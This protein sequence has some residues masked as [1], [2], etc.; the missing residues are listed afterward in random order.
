M[1]IDFHAHHI[2]L[3]YATR[4]ADLTWRENIQHHIIDVRSKTVVDIGCG[5]G[6]YTLAL[7][8]M[9]ATHVTGIDF[10][11]AEIESAQ[12]RYSAISNI[13]FMVGDAFST[14]L[15]ST[16]YDIV[17][18][19]ALIHHLQQEDLV[20][21]FAEARRILKPRG[22]LIVQDRTPED[23]MLPG[24]ETHIRSYIVTHFPKLLE[25]DV[26]RR[27]SS[28]IVIDALR[29]AGFEQI[30]EQKLWETRQTYKDIDELAQDISQRTGRSI[31]HD[32]TDEELQVLVVAM[33]ERLKD[34]KGEIVEQDRWTVWSA[35]SSMNTSSR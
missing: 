17:L 18:E 28:Q 26:V 19:R 29:K 21:C 12:E 13:T 16:Q 8:E 22:M 10:S 30:E 4:Q 31:L 6:I 23:C 27:H 35:I 15:Q 2:R 20:R 14:G 25:K 11:Q 34:N 5:G 9:G 33:R 3:S 32:L 1:P 24:S 7:T